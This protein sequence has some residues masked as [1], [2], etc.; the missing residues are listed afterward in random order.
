MDLRKLDHVPSM[1]AVMTPFPFS[2]GVHDP[3]EKAWELMREHK[4]HHV[5]VRDQHAL[6]GIVSQRDLVAFGA[7]NHADANGEPIKVGYVCVPD[8]FVVEV[9]APLDRVAL[10][11]AERH[12]GSAIVVKEGRLAG[13]FTTTD[14]TRLLG[15]ILHSRFREPGDD[16]VA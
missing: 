5:P 13:I 12:I 15:E 7:Q 4:I 10:E 11:M 6:V 1:A 2:V 16:L 8:P 9:S 14:A 3:L